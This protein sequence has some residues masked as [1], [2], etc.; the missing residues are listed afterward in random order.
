MFV[1]RRVEG[2]VWALILDPGNVPVLFPSNES[3]NDKQSA[4]PDRSSLSPPLVVENNEKAT[5]RWLL[6]DKK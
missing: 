2:F 1:H 6:I 4:R 5:G 3:E